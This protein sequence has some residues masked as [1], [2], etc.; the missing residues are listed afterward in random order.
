M[1]GDASQL[2]FEWL[3]AHD[4]RQEDV[5][6]WSHLRMCVICFFTPA[7]VGLMVSGQ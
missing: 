6:S 5:C 2:L 1:E 3:N 4:L 7:T